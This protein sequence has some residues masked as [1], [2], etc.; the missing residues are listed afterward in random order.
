MYFNVLY[1]IWS[2]FYG[3]HNQKEKLHSFIRLKLSDMWF[4]ED[5]VIYSL[6]SKIQVKEI[7][8]KYKNAY[9]YQLSLDISKN[10]S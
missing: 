9:K 6:W 2:C 4:G 8:S 7:Y 5:L 10:I 1:H 3:A